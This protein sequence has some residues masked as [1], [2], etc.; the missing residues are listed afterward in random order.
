LLSLPLE[1]LRRNAPAIDA[2]ERVPRQ[3]L[4]QLAQ[5]GLFRLTGPAD[6]VWDTSEALAVACGTTNFVQ[7]QHQGASRF[8]ASNP[9]H[10]LEP[11]LEGT[12]LCGV[13]F[14]HLRRPNSPVQV[15]RRPNE[16]IFRGEAPWFTGWGI[17]DD[18]VLAGREQDGT[19]TYAVVPLSHPG[20]RP[21]QQLQLSAIHASSTVSLTLEDVVVPESSFVLRQ[22][23]EEMAERDFRSQLGY[24]AL[25]LGLTR[26]ACRIMAQ[27]RS[28]DTVME[29]FL[30]RASALRVRALAWSEDPEE[31]LQIRAAANVLA[32]QAAQAAVVSVGGL[33]NVLRHPACRLVREASFYF[34]T[35]LNEPLRARYLRLLEHSS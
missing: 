25:P 10:E 12:R 30:Q 5:L 21:G 11:Y 33:A 35:Q 14:A 15:E 17:F 26:E 7:A 28:Q 31:A 1:Q 19:D 18:V 29:R 20:I 23:R 8:L 27:Q 22:T 32:H 13:A 3:T 4:Q 9:A 34:L 6:V 16:L 2:A 24:A